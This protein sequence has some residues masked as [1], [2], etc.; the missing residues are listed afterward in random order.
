MRRSAYSL[1]SNSTSLQRVTFPPPRSLCGESLNCGLPPPLAARKDDSRLT[2]VGVAKLP[3]P[4]SPCRIGEPA[5]LQPQA[6]SQKRPTHHKQLEDCLCTYAR[7]GEP[8]RSR[9]WKDEAGTG[10]R[11]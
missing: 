2:F 6:T 7:E 8:A 10:L 3:P 4:P 1:V 9:A 5:R 11:S